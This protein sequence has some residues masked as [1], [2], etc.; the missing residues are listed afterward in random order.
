MNKNELEKLIAKYDQQADKAYQDYQATGLT[1]YDTA[2][3]KAEDLADALRMALTAEDDHN[4]LIA[5][6]CAVSEWA[7]TIQR[8]KS[9]PEKG[10]SVETN[11][12][13][14]AILSTARMHG[15]CMED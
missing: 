1:R 3:R 4:R 10:K 9:I 5:L 13:L 8:L 12:L 11:L 2:R 15:L 6:R 14:K 7:G